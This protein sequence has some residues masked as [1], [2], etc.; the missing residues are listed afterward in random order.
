MADVSVQQLIQ[1]F[2]LVGGAT[3]TA[4]AG[5]YTALQQRKQAQLTTLLSAL[6]QD[7]KDLR[8]ENRALRD[9]I[10]RIGRGRIRDYKQ[11]T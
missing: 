3:I 1:L 4:A 11:R 5:Y 6:Q 7:N 8:E 9:E 2:A 10:E